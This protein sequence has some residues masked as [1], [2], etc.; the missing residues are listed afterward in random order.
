MA[1]KVSPS[2]RAARLD[3]AVTPEKFWDFVTARQEIWYCRFELKH[4]PPWTDDSILQR[5]FFCNV[6]RELDKGT[7]WYLDYVAPRPGTFGSLDFVDVLFRTIVYRLVNSVAVFEKVGMGGLRDWPV[8]IGEMRKQEIKP[9][10]PAYLILPQPK[11]LLSHL[12]RLE[13]LLKRLEPAIEKLAEDIYQEES[14]EG[15]SQLLQAQ[16][17]IG[18]F[19]AMQVYR[20]LILAKVLFYDEDSWTDIGPGAVPVLRALTGSSKREDWYACLE[21]LRREEVPELGRRGFH[22]YQ[23]KPLSLCD[24]QQAICEYRKYV[25]LSMGMGK[26]R[27]YHGS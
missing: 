9:Y 6:Y 24:I 25:M 20:D 22:F 5:F 2:L 13:F 10:S 3:G 19:V 11:D 7:Q 16:Y 8:M 21:A 23:D 18:L 27:Y 1:S 4:P 14:L 12:D 15:V 26:R 17:G